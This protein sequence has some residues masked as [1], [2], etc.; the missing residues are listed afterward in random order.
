MPAVLPSGH[1]KYRIAVTSCC[2]HFDMVEQL[3]QLYRQL[4]LLP[5]PG[6]PGSDPARST[7]PCNSTTIPQVQLDFVL[8]A[9]F[10]EGFALSP[11]TRHRSLLS[12]GWKVIP[13]VLFN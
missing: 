9:L 1:R 5:K 12:S 3:L 2:G 7:L 6:C 8:C 4:S 13:D 11:Q 10:Q